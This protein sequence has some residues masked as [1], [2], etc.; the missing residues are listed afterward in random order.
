MRI[1]LLTA[2]A[3]LTLASPAPAEE[4]SP[5]A[6]ALPTYT[7]LPYLLTR[8]I[9]DDDGVDKHQCAA[10]FAAINGFV[11]DADML[12]AA[13]G[14]SAEDRAAVVAAA[15]GLT[16][17]AAQQLVYSQLPDTTDTGNLL[18]L[19]DDID[20]RINTYCSA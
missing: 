4:F 8:P 11:H 13:S 1:P 14:A 2:L 7:G 20:A 15:A 17:S 16:P 9:S 6:G 12:L 18:D 10:G 19:P 5:Q 3:C